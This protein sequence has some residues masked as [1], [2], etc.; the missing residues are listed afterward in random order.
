VKEEVKENTKHKEEEDK[1]KRRKRCQAIF[2]FDVISWEDRGQCAEE[3]DLVAF[4]VSF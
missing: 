4:S 1:D 3:R 2:S